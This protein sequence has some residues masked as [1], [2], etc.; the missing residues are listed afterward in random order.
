[1]RKGRAS[2]TAQFVSYNR[3]LADLAPSVPGF[4]DPVAQKFLGPRWTGNVGRMREKIAAGKA[5]S[6]FPIWFRGMGI[7]N[8]FRT[9]VLDHAVLDHA[10]PAALPLNQLVILGAG[11]DSRAWRLPRLESTLVF[12]VDHPDTQIVKRERS[13][14][15]PSTAREIRFVSADLAEENLG[16]RLAEA[17]YRTDLKTFWLW[18]GVTMYL[19]PELVARNLESMAKLSSPGSGL[20]FTY[21]AKRNGKIPKALFLALLGEPVRSAFERE[22]L[23]GLASRTGWRT[24]SNS[25]IEDWKRAYAPSLALTERQVGLQWNERIWVGERTAGP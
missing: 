3:A 10:V 17:G 23:D 12:E 5:R 1:V 25:G 13:A 15:L 14:G 11:F 20:A 22:E 16:I 19:A 9:V 8:Q 7:F 24:N 21:M 6:P 18:E 4:S 2:Q